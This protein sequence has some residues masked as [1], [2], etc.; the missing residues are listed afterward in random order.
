MNF[1]IVSSVTLFYTNEFMAALYFLSQIL[2]SAALELI[3]VRSEAMQ[4]ASDLSPGG[5]MT[6][7]VRADT[8]LG[9]ACSVAKEY[10]QKIGVQGADCRIASFLHPTCKVVAGSEEVRGAG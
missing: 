10:C 1:C 9:F 7:F 6:A 8:R 4:I 5:M 2:F 3:K